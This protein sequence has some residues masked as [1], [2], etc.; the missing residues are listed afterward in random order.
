VGE[1][2]GWTRGGRGERMHKRWERREGGQEVGEERCWTRGGR[3]ERVD[4]RWNMIDLF[5]GS[6]NSVAEV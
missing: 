6:V 4:K 3:G 1:E 5:H 2:R